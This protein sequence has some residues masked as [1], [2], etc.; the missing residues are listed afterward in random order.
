L[1]LEL[2]TGGIERVSNRNMRVFVPPGCCRVAAD[3]DVLATGQRNVKANT[4]AVVGATPVLRTGDH[5][6]SGRDVIVEALGPSGFLA[7][8]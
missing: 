5:H 6:P 2:A 1:I 8:S 4:I 3:V 7:N